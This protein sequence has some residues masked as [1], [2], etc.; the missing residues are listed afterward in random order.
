[1]QKLELIKFNQFDKCKNFNWCSRIYWI[2]FWCFVIYFLKA[3]IVRNGIIYYS[4]LEI[5]TKTIESLMV[6]SIVHQIVQVCLYDKG[7][8]KRE[9]I[10]SYSSRQRLGIILSKIIESKSLFQIDLIEIS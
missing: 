4:L 9:S 5:Y 2:W 7:L 8:F 3:I 10:A 1:M 6:S